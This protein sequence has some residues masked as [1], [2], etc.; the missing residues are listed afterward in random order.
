MIPEPVTGTPN[1]RLRRHPVVEPVTVTVADTCAITGLGRTKV[2]E[3]IS[4]QV[5]KTVAV[6]RRRLILMESIKALLK[7]GE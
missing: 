2:Y 7:P 3:L 5:L 4:Q 6:G 1:R